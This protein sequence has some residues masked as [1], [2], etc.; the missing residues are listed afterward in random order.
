MEVIFGILSREGAPDGQLLRAL[1]QNFYS[2]PG[3]ERH[4]ATYLEGP[5]GLGRLTLGPHDPGDIR[6]TGQ[7]VC[8]SDA[9]LYEVPG[10]EAPVALDVLGRDACLCTRFT[11]D[12][13]AAIEGDFAAARWQDGQLTLARDAMGVRPLYYAD[14]PHGVLFA[15][16]PE[17]ILR[18]GLLDIDPVLKPSVLQNFWLMAHPDQTPIPGLKRLPAAHLLRIGESGE[19]L[20]RYW[21]FE[22]PRQLSRAT[23]YADCVKNMRQKVERAVQLRLAAADRVGGHLSSGLDCCSVSI[24]AARSAPEGTPFHS[25]SLVARPIPGVELPDERRLVDTAVQSEP[26]IW[27]HKIT[28]ADQGRPDPGEAFARHA[29]LTTPAPHESDTARAARREGVD[30]ILSGWG[31]DEC[32]SFNARGALAEYAVRFRW[33]HMWRQAKAMARRRGTTPVREIKSDWIGYLLPDALLRPLARLKGKRPEIMASDRIA[34]IWKTDA[35]Q[36]KP[37]RLGPNTRR[38]RIK[39]IRQGHI[40]QRLETWARTGA[41][42]GVRYAFP[43]LDRRLMRWAITLPTDMFLRDGVKRAIYRD[44]MVGVLP[45]TIRMNRRKYPTFPEIMLE[46]AEALPQ[47]R[48]TLAT[49]RNDPAMEHLLDLPLLQALLDKGPDCSEV[50][51]ALSADAAGG[52]RANFPELSAMLTFEHAELLRYQE[53]VRA[54]R[55]KPPQARS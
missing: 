13:L 8:V 24:L 10:I 9:R 49:W 1:A 54:G 17:M 48:E 45:E 50:K 38:T 22:A 52:P 55:V 26:N 18:T 2:A 28:R 33:W 4:L 44:A 25:F 29:M 11:P 36:G 31:G 6:K 46:W 41:E 47:A 7:G 23:P 30:V 20:H 12:D 40:E 42:Y 51:A 34:A 16:F 37:L 3:L 19:Q 15:S 35:G 39:L 53:A 43:L 21:R 32:V 5:V 14:T 27:N